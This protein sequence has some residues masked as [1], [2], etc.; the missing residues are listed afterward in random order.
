MKNHTDQFSHS[1][2]EVRLSESAKARIR[3][4]LVVHME[5]HPV[6]TYRL[7]PYQYLMGAQ[8][9]F[10]TRRVPMIACMFLLIFAVGGATTFAAEGALPGDP[11]YALKV[12]VIEPVRGLVAVSP[13]ANA[14]WHVSLAETRVS[15]VEQLAAKQELTPEEG[16]KSKERLDKSLEE[17][18]TTLEKLNEDDPE[19]VVRVAASFTVSL[20]KHQ[21]VLDTIGASASSTNASEARLFADHIRQRVLFG[22]FASTTPRGGRQTPEEDAP[23]RDRAP[24]ERNQ[25]VVSTTTPSASSSVRT[26]LDD[27]ES[28]TSSTTIDSRQDASEE[29]KKGGLTGQIKKA[30][31]I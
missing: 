23:Q 28:S 19:A 7:S 27:H 24:Q 13:E 1:A 31:G 17:V 22:K 29:S 2:H 9:F 26:L 14:A 15:E 10:T 8:S 16:L 4:R 18:R 11:L 3:E 20:E 21:E 5:E 25:D 30:I 6:M 12:S